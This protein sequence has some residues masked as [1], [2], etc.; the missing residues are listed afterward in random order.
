VGVNSSAV[1]RNIFVKSFATEA[2]VAAAE[3]PSS[4][5][6]PAV[7]AVQFFSHLLLVARSHRL[8]NINAIDLRH[9]DIPRFNINAI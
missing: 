3:K 5:R 9:V 8:A 1:I 2:R 4:M 6:Y 7:V